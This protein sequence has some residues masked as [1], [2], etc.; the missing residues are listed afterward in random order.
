MR[1]NLL[2]GVRIHSARVAAQ[3]LIRQGA[4]CATPANITPTHQ[5][6]N[7]ISYYVAFPVVR[8]NYYVHWW[9]LVWWLRFNVCVGAV[10]WSV[11]LMAMAAII[12]SILLAVVRSLSGTG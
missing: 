12:P 3:G 5:R 8:H 1:F 4:Q 2:I 10:G 7:Y 11:Q 6:H 9:A